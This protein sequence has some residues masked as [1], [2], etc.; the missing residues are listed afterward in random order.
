VKKRLR[1]S[2]ILVQATIILTLVSGGLKADTGTCGGA[3]TTIPFTDVGSSIFFCQIAEA[4]F[5]GLTN[6]TSATTFSPS[7]PVN[8]EQMAAF[9]TRTQ[10]SALMRGS[11]RAAASQFWTTTPH[12]DS[13]LGTTAVGD[14][15]RLVASDGTDLWVAGVGLTRV[16]ASDGLALG[17]WT[18]K[19]RTTA[20]LVAM[21]RVFA[22]GFSDQ[23]TPGVLY[24]ID[25]SQSPG[26]LTNVATIGLTP[27]GLAFD[28]SRIWTA[29]AGGCC[30][31]GSV[32]IITP[33]PTL[34]WPV[35]TIT[36]VGFP[37]GILYDG[38]NIWVASAGNAAMLKLDANG[39]IVQTIRVPGNPNTPVFDGTNIWVP[40]YNA[41]NISVV[42]ASTGAI[43]AT[44]TGNGLEGPWVAAFDGQ[45]ILVTSLNA[46]SVS[47][48]RAADLTPIG[49]VA[50]PGG[51]VGACSD[52]LNFWITLGSANQLARF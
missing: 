30:G 52:G 23:L 27:V 14:G 44:L 18:G 40:N 13:G 9:M 41:N 12:Y 35:T 15:P 42:R 47:L 24:M 50:A 32:S 34:P 45:R 2:L 22:T 25:P 8:R 38:T 43:V 4:Y 36:G 28:G 46:S 37:E 21:G 19:T 6:G 16:R 11:G 48:W 7:D 17:T 1:S 31:N 3:M 39:N 33:G 29:D 10:D 51:A 49:S 5:S 26:T 20:P